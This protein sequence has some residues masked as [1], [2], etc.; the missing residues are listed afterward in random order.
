MKKLTIEKAK[1]IAN[2]ISHQI[3]PIDNREFFLIHSEKVWKV[4][5][6]IAEKLW[7]PTDIF[8]IAGRIHDIWYA[9]NIEQH[10]D[11]SI[12]ILEE[13]W[14][15]I[16]DILKDC[17]LN[18]W[19]NKTPK[20]KEWIIFQIADK[21]NIIDSDII[22]IVLKYWPFPISDKDLTFLKN[23]SKNAFRLLEN[24]KVIFTNH[25]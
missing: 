8:E 11:F 1:K 6:I 5:K 25:L 4:A 17:I 24:Y 10:S 21:L 19:N 12:S 14:Y 16:N 2:N 7:L 22:K 15:E 20:T 3:N 9:K 18:H 23:M 13:L